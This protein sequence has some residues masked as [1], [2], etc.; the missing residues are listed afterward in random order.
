M[1]R[2]LGAWVLLTKAVGLVSQLLRYS[3]NT[4]LISRQCLSVASGLWLGKEGPFVHVACCCSN[5]F[6]RFFPALNEN[7]GNL[8]PYLSQRQ[9]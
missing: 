9:T 5:L 6:L 7:E 8:T 3:V 1:K 2:F 4:L